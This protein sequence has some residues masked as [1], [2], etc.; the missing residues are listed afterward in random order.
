ML[1]NYNL[2]L[3]IN[4]SYIGFKTSLN[5]PINEMIF[6]KSFENKPFYNYMKFL[7]E[8]Q[9]LVSNLNEKLKSSTSNQ[10]KEIK[11]QLENIDKEVIKFRDNF[12]NRNKKIF[13]TDIIKASLEP[14]IPD[15]ATN[16]NNNDKELKEYQLNYYIN[17]YWDNINLLDSGIIR[18]TFFFS[19][20]DSPK[21]CIRILVKILICS[22]NLYFFS[23]LSEF[24]KANSDV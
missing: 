3:V 9:K 8:K 10:N 2:Q 11:I 23:K 7:N 24:E 12:I 19:L 21:Y 4:E 6:N 5:N 14:I 13:F 22:F 18:T 1:P 16:I 20:S 17:H 15:P